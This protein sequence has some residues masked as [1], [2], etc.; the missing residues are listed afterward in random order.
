MRQRLIRLVD[1][2][3]VSFWFLPALLLLA[4]TVLAWGALLADAAH[5]G[6]WG[7]LLFNGGP[8]G[9][10]TI[11]GTIAGSMVTVGTTVF[12]ITMVALTLAS[13]QFG[14]R[15]L[16]NFLRDRGNQL[17]IGLFLAVFLY[18]LIV[19][20]G[21]H[22]RA[23]GVPNLAVSL[24]IVLAVA[25]L[26]VLVYFIHHIATSIQVMN[27][28]QLLADDLSAG[29][30]SSVPEAGES[31]DVVVTRPELPPPGHAVDAAS[32]GYVQYVDRSALVRRAAERDLVLRLLVRPGRFVV[33]GS[34]LARAWTADGRAAT[35][36]QCADLA[37]LVS[38]GPRRSIAQDVE[39]PIRQL[40][41]VGL[42]ALS[43]GIND[44]TTA[45]ACLN[46]LSVGLSR[47]ADRPMP[48]DVHPDGDGVA[49]LVQEGPLTWARLVGGAFDQLRQAAGGHV[50]V[51]LHLLEALTTIAGRTTRLDRLTVLRR[52][53]DL[54]WEAAQ[55]A[56]AQAADLEVVRQRHAALLAAVGGAG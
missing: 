53:G 13:S 25:A 14:P 26:M 39:F 15:M 23:G 17:T 33:A 11:L 5:D 41:E 16:S 29:L 54:V 40:V 12:S 51:H 31:P 6:T 10:R 19:L 1:Q 30:D 3:R 48:P 37:A 4:A 38:V 22:D 50:V 46:Q 43:P 32:S 28:V 20:R 47:V 21:V 24:A 7:G 42:R 56:V 8:Q 9:A 52:Q 27:L 34:P 35:D 49:R 44:P 2:L 55:Q 18:S 45:T 36:E